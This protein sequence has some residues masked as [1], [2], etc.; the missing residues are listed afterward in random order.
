MNDLTDLYVFD[1]LHKVKN[2]EPGDIVRISFMDGF[3]M[4]DDGKTL[5]IVTLRPFEKQIRFTTA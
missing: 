5:K 1:I 2:M 4:S 3:K